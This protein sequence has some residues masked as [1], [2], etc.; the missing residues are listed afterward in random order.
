MNTTQQTPESVPVATS[1]PAFAPVASAPAKQEASP[2]TVKRARLPAKK[3]ASEVS[4]VTKT[5]ATKTVVR[6][7]AVKKVTAEAIPPA[8]PA[9]KTAAKAP[10]FKAVVAA[11]PEKAA[12]PHK[13]KKDKLVRDS[14]TIPKAEYAVID[15]LKQRAAKLNSP[16]KKS[17][18]L[19]AGIKI[20][21]TLSNAALLTA[22]TQ[23]PTIKTGRPALKK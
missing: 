21:A 6:K 1:P 10:V 7:T 5:P 14:F 9:Q 11:K 3:A 16:V 8:I 22:L 13:A 19:R 12:T 23:V 17:E 2:V 18:L 20:L 15:E 4:P